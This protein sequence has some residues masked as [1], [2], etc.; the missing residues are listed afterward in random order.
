MIGIQMNIANVHNVNNNNIKRRNGGNMG[1]GERA[2]A[3][4]HT[5]LGCVRVRGEGG[6]QPSN[7]QACGSQRRGSEA[8]TVDI[9]S[10]GGRTRSIANITSPQV[11]QAQSTESDTFDPGRREVVDAVGAYTSQFVPE[12]GVIRGFADN[13][14]TKKED[15][16]GRSSERN[17]W[18]WLEATDPSTRDLSLPIN[19]S[20]MKGL[21]AEWSR[22]FVSYKVEMSSLTPMEDLSSDTT[23]PQ[24]AEDRAAL[25][26]LP[27][28]FRTTICRSLEIA[29]WMQSTVDFPAV[30]PMFQEAYS[31]ADME[32]GVAEAVKSG[33]GYKLPM[34]KLIRDMLRMEANDGSLEALAQETLTRREPV[35]LSIT[36]IELSLD[37]LGLD[38]RSAR[39]G[40]STDVAI[41]LI[42]LARIALR[43]PILPEYENFIPTPKPPKVR[44]LYKEVHACVNRSFYRLWEQE[45]CYML[46]TRLI[47][48]VPRAHFTPIGFILKTGSKDGRTLFDAKDSRSRT[49]LNPMESDAYKDDIRVEWGHLYHPDL[50]DICTMVLEF[51][52]RMRSTLGPDFSLSEVVLFKVDLKSAFH[53]V[54]LAPHS[55][56]L[57]ACEMYEEEWPLPAHTG[58]A[59]TPREAGSYAPLS[60]WTYSRYSY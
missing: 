54:S 40:M 55:V 11:L 29:G 49:P 18:Q 24:Q 41:D 3:V 31:L 17:L 42:R 56:P 44:P 46:P 37:R 21:Y 22:C 5:P 48:R 15:P 7:L 25:P 19:P 50:D 1:K 36:R 60:T 16:Q 20:F 2:E 10:N 53:L 12:D 35:R 59:S 23:H 27:E 6:S 13:L 30:E 45:L 34:D 28:T 47:M 26:V 33:D 39:T 8:A 57:L 43:G 32:Y 38:E 4:G 58:G 9:V 51:E 14:L 52:D